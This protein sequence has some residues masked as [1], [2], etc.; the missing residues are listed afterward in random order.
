MDI[1]SVIKEAHIIARDFGLK[2][3]KVLVYGFQTDNQSKRS[4]S[5]TFVRRLVSDGGI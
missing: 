5:G 4:R 1:D 3:R 2:Q